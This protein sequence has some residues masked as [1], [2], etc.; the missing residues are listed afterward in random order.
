MEVQIISRELIKPSSPTV[1][2]KR[3]YK[4]TLLDQLTPTTYSPLILFYPMNNISTALQTLTHLKES[5]SQT[6]NLYYPFSGRPTCDNLYI[7]R[8]NE[9]VPFFE[10]KVNCSMS[11][12]LKLH[13]TELLN[14][15]LPCNPYTKEV[16]ME[17]PIIAFQVSMFTCG[18]ITLGLSMSHKLI[19]A[20]TASAFLSNWTSLHRRD[21]NGV[22]A[23]YLHE[24]SLF[25]PSRISFPQD[26]LSLMESLWFT[27]ANYITKRFS[28][29]PKAIAT[30][31]TMAKGDRKNNVDQPTRIE[32]LSC[33]IWKY[34]MQASSMV[35]SSRGSESRTSILVEA[36]D[37]RKKTKPPMNNGSIGNLF[38]WAVAVADPNDKKNTELHE[39]ASLLSE[40]VGVYKTEY[41]HS[42]Q[43]DNGH[44]TMSEYCEQLS[45]LF[46]L[47][48]PDIFAFTSWCNT[49]ATKLDFGW[50]EPY[51]VGVMGKAGAAFRN[52]TV[53]VD[54]KDGKG[55]E[56]WITLDDERMEILQR[57]PEFLAFASP[58]PRIS[59]L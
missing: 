25:F 49:S 51:W 40:S 29:N 27:E 42:L 59:S 8:F 55:V 15:F 7:N 26:H 11:E 45:E 24:P 28:F 34:C 5:L 19:D 20:A 22:M 46:S 58:N 6:L 38:W 32:T 44:E 47:E 30:L 52:L 54:A 37:L 39:L 12:F 48:K 36:V 33:F 18:G 10:A 57:N 41:T 17:I 9:G 35:E 56:A 21:F 2:H 43:G 13:Q 50:G 1:Q 53:F 23:P 14:S 16:S 3:P 31:K 4:L